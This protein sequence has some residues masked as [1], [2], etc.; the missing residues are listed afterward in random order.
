MVSNLHV[1][2]V[3]FIKVSASQLDKYSLIVRVKI[4]CIV[5]SHDFWLIDQLNTDFVSRESDAIVDGQIHHDL[6]R[7]CIHRQWTAHMCRIEKATQS[8]LVCY[9]IKLA[10]KAAF[11]PSKLLHF[12]NASPF[13][14][15]TLIVEKWLSL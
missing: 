1:Q 6:L 12:P 7:H 2:L 3:A 15:D 9:R 4:L 13:L 14:L 8:R 10:V 11:E 5:H